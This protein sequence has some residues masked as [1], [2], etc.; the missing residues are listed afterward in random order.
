[1]QLPPTGN[2]R[3]VAVSDVLDFNCI[4]SCV[5]IPEHRLAHM[6]D[7]ESYVRNVGSEGYVRIIVCRYVAAVCAVDVIASA[8]VIN[9]F[10]A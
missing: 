9:S 7:D 4:R 8:H 3:L 10:R 1:M 6:I 2:V 5:N